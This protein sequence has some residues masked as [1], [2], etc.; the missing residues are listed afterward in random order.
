MKARLW[1]MFCLD[2]GKTGEN[3]REITGTAS[4]GGNGEYEARQGVPRHDGWGSDR[5]RHR[6]YRTVRPEAVPE[7]SPWPI[8]TT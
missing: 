8:Q 7:S 4:A 3:A 6:F 2:T 1:F 5:D